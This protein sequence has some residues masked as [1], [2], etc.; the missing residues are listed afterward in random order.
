LSERDPNRRRSS[1]DSRSPI[2]KN[3]VAVGIIVG[4]VLGVLL[5]SITLYFLR[6]PTGAPVNPADLEPVRAVAPRPTPTA[7]SPAG[8]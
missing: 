3:A 6:A 5:G 8:S 7:P 2:P 4:G 1:A